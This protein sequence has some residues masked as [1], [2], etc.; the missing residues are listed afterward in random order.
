MNACIFLIVYWAGNKF[1]ALYVYVVLDRMYIL[2]SL[3]LRLRMRMN[4]C[5]L[6][7]E[8]VDIIDFW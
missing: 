7:F 6:A 5:S 8:I 2:F 3:W 4:A 1:G